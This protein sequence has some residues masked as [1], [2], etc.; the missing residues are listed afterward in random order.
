MTSLDKRTPAMAA[1]LA[2]RVWTVRELVGLLE[3]A[4]NVPMKRGSYKRKLNAA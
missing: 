4:E 2:D 1:G 3:E